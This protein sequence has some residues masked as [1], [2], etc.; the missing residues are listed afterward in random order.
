MIKAKVTITWNEKI[1]EAFKY[2]KQKLCSAPILV[3]PNFSKP[4][5]LYTDVLKLGLS[6]ILMQE[7]NDKEEHVICYTSRGL[8]PHKENYTTTKLECLAMYWAIKHF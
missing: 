3:H 6:V 7:D 1:I 8:Y 2:L 5:I 4:F